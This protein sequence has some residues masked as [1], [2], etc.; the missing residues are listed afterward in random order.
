MNLYLNASTDFAIHDETGRIY[1]EAEALRL[2]EWCAAE[3]AK[4]AARASPAAVPGLEAIPGAP[5]GETGASG[6]ETGSTRDAGSE[7]TP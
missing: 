7:P 1:S 3:Y 2:I 5:E 4:N 6:R